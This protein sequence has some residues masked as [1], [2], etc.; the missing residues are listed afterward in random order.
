M[1]I[2]GLDIGTTGCKLTIFTAAGEY[3][4]KAY[5]GYPVKRQ[6]EGHEIDVTAIMDSV[7]QVIDQ[8]SK[9]FPDILGIGV[10]SLGET[11]VM[12]DSDGMPLHPA[13]LYTDPRGK[14]ECAELV[15]ALGERKIANITG[16]RP[17]EVYSISKMMW[18]KKHRPEIY[19]AAKHI[20]LM[21]DYVVFRLT[22][23]TQIDYSLAS[24]T[25]A[26]DIRTLEWSEDIFEVAG[27]DSA[28]MSRPVPTGT[29]AGVLTQE[30]AALT[31]L[32]DNARIISVS[33]DQIAAAIGAGA[34]D[35]EIL[36]DGA[37]TT[38]CLTPIF[39]DMPDMEVM[40]R[41]HFS[42]APYVIPNKYVA[43]AF[44]NTSGALMEWCSSMLA[45]KEAEFA[46]DENISVNEYLERN[47]T[48]PTGL[49]VLPHFAGAG[50]PYMDTGSKGAIIGLTTET[51]V[52]DIYRGC[53][54]GVAYEMYLN[55]LA[56]KDAGVHFTKVHATGGGARSSEWMQMKADVWN[57]PIVAFEM[58]DAG[59][60]GSAMLTG[61]AIGIFANL[62]E[63]A[64]QMVE[65]RETFYPRE[66][67]H[68]K[69]MELFK[70]YRQLYEAVR[71]LV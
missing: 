57:V 38:E 62:D 69:Y 12:T 2:G 45:K 3:L 9:K 14:A 53:M 20:F 30:V 55:M 24:R 68:E 41:G 6:K 19:D 29:D 49:L 35:A 71:P 15:D 56:L 7:F 65:I 27:I 37:G 47:S 4:D 25:M 23:K 11:F 58:S 61:I 5:C 52:A 46:G 1:K 44:S 50:T 70:S 43:Y 8:M 39:N 54:E 13:M 36:A 17:S 66:E 26:F 63:A 59:T 16:V 64:K 32:A 33:H 60:V 67:M 42:V 51:T 22:G 48:S 18:L 31:G 21:E 40:N 34:F 10:T 28:L